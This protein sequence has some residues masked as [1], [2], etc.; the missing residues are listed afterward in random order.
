MGMLTQVSEDA[1]RLAPVKAHE[2]SHSTQQGLETLSLDG[3]VVT[4]CLG[5][6]ESFP[7][8]LHQVWGAMKIPHLITPSWYTCSEDDES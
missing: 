3:D 1:H 7:K 6:M 2:G 4:R 5:L 8:N